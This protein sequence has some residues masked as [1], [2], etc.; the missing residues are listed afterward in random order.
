M[1]EISI[2]YAFISNKWQVFFRISDVYL[3]DTYSL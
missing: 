1:Y 2:F 3:F